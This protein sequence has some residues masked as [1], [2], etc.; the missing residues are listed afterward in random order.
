MQILKSVAFVMLVNT[1]VVKDNEDDDDDDDDV[2]VID[3]VSL[4]HCKSVSK[5]KQ[6]TT[7]PLSKYPICH[8]TFNFHL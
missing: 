2:I 8:E 3:V 4:H 6:I 5:V 7:L 1:N